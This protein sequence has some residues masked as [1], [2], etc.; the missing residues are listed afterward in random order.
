MTTTETAIDRT[1][2]GALIPEDAA[3]DIIK[4]LPQQSAA[5]ST[6]RHVTM[7]RKQKRLPVLAALPV[8]YWVSPSDTGQKQ[9]TDAEWDNVYLEAEELACIVP[10]PEAVLDDADFDIWG[11]IKPA[12]AESMGAK[13]DLATIFGSGAPSSWPNSLVEEAL[14]TQHY[15]ERGGHD[16]LWQDL[17][18]EGGLLH[19]VE[20]DGFDP[21]FAIARLGF[22]AALRGESDENGR[23]IWSNVPTPDGVSSVL[24]DGTPI[25]W[26][27]NGGWVNGTADMVIG[28]SS[29]AIIGVR[30]DITYK[31]LDQAVIQNVDGT[32]A[33]NL[34]QQDMV[35]LRVVMRVGF[36]TANP[37]TR[38]NT[39]EATRCPF[40]YLRDSVS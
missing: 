34:A 1:G 32:I 5:L 38:L 26:S 9:T 30:Q 10:I 29:K 23:P 6:F 4:M 17:F 40:A 39:V 35:A 21:D 14:A 13:I 12:I 27:K 22:K 31:M 2:A 3:N 7:S 15:V 37:P 19:R 8:A 28:D 18:D 16:Q 33:Y 36:A 24:S 11:E 25:F 20:V